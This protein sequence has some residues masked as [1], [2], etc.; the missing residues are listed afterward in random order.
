MSNQILVGMLL[1]TRLWTVAGNQAAVNTVNYYCLTSG[2]TPTTDQAFANYLDTQVQIAYKGLLSADAVYRGIQC[3]LYQVGGQPYA[4]VFSNVNAGAGTDGASLVPT[5]CRGLGS[6]Q[7]TL[8]GRRFRGRYYFAFPSVN[9]FLSGG[10]PTAAYI[11]SMQTVLG[12]YL[13]LTG[14]IAAGGGTFSPVIVHRTGKSPT[15]SPTAIITS[16]VSTRVATQRRSGSFGR[17]NI[18]PI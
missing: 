2:G 6:L 14:P 13:G 9:A 15:P 1:K 4:P 3:Q 11:L 5:Q 12:I 10:V 7:T 17:A 16:T 8:A 18:S